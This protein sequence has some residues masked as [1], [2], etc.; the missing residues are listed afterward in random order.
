MEL[1][2]TKDEELTVRTPAGTQVVIRLTED[3][4]KLRLIAD[5]VTL[6]SDPYDI[7]EEGYRGGSG[8]RKRVCRI[9]VGV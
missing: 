1:E 8:T 2:L 3:G 9:L 4:E 7:Y 5:W 6:L